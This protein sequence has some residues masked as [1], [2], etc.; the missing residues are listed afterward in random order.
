MS[1][2]WPGN[3]RQLESVIERAVILADG[4][5]IQKRDLPPEIM[6]HVSATGDVSKF[7][8]PESGLNLEELEKHLIQQAMRKAGGVMS[9][10]APMLG[11][12][13]RT[14]QYRLQKYGLE[15]LKQE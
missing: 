1:Y 4:N 7:D 13:Y 2:E 10:A 5:I 15:T 3:V 11:L 8:L 12:S 9:K 6:E 14:L